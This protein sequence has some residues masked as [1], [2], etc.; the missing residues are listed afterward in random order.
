MNTIRTFVACAVAAASLTLGG[1]GCSRDLA[2]KDVQIQE[3]ERVNKDLENQ[4]AVKATNEVTRIVDK[5]PPNQAP[6]VTARDA[7]GAGVNVSDRDREVIFSIESSILFKAGSSDLTA[8]AKES[9]SRVV[10]IIKQKYPNHY[11]RVEGHTDDQPIS[12]TKNKW[13]DNWDLAGGRARQVL[14]YLLE[15]GVAASDLG[16]AGYADQRPVAPGKAESSR[17]KNRHVEIVVIPKG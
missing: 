13:E 4:L 17:Q 10:A 15:R 1:C 14:H 9:I 11:V 12:R 8:P 3:L 5:A 2:Y 7:A 16:F 6:L